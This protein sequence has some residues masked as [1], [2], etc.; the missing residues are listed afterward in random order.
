MT[1]VST[2]E[3]YPASDQNGSPR[4]IDGETRRRYSTGWPSS[5]RG[6]QK[7]LGPKLK[8]M[9]YE[10]IKAMCLKEGKLF[11]DP[12]FDAVDSILYYDSPTDKR[13]VWQRPKV[14]TVFLSFPYTCVSLVPL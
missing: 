5:G 2:F 4:L 8:G 14:I 13:Y 12:D 9:K 7:P 11:E 6:S 3:Y 1:S 10:E